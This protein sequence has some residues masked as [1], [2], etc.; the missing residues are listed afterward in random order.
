MQHRSGLI[1]GLY[2]LNPCPAKY[3]YHSLTKTIEKGIKIAAL[4]GK[5]RKIV[6]R[7]PKW[8]GLIIYIENDVEIY[9]HRKLVASLVV[10]SF[11]VSLLFLFWVILPQNSTIPTESGNVLCETKATTIDDEDLAYYWAPIVYQDTDS[12]D[13]SADYITNFNFDGDWDGCNNWE[14]KDNYPLN[15]WA[16][17]W[18]SETDTNWFI[19]YAFFHPRDWEEVNSDLISHENDLEGILLAIQK[20][21]SGYGKFLAMVTLAHADFYSFKDFDEAPS[22]DVWEGHES[23]DGDV[24]FMGSHPKIYIQAQGHGIVGDPAKTLPDDMTIIWKFDLNGDYVIYYPYGYAEVPRGGNDRKVSYALR[25]IDE[26][27]Q[28]REDPQVFAGYG[29]FKGDTYGHNKANAPWAW[30]D[31]DDGEIVAGEFFTDPAHLIDYYFTGL[32]N[33]ERNY[34]YKSWE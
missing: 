16:Y 10:G 8:F 2:P 7:S 18:I 5:F 29:T 13:Y 3:G 14:N 9:V 12:S 6:Q 34:I 17:Y 11:M 26:L 32:G 30:D 31:H 25:A 1:S 24:D 27:W 4:V 20:D 21:S 19:G 22:K 33:F 23:I 15:A 28:R